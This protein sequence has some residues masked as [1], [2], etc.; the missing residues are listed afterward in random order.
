[1]IWLSGYLCFWNFLLMGEF[2]TH[3]MTVLG[4]MVSGDGHTGV[5]LSTVLGAMSVRCVCTC[6]PI[7]KHALLFCV[8]HC[9]Y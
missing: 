2:S 3:G 7:L 1:M 9:E 5:S 8:V 6:L 4:K